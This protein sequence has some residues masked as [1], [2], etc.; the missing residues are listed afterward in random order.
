M[1][2]D[3]SPEELVQFFKALAEANR[4][5]MVGLLAQKPYTGEQLSVLLGLSVS[6]VS[7]HLSKLAK[8]GLVE[9]RAEGYYNVYS[10]KTN[11]LEEMARRVFSR[12]KLPR[13]AQNVDV[14]AFD[15]KVLQAFV[16]ADGR[17]MAFP[18]QEKKLLVI[19]RYVL[20][21]FEPGLRYPEKQVNEILS[22]FNEDTATLRRCLV[23]YHLMA[24][25]GGGGAYWRLEERT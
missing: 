12:E 8:A 24:R 6:T 10:L 18:K 11:V 20:K 14:D 17:I 19:L 15:H 4:L 13:L 25:E 9:A 5:K 3:G 21:A 16:D 23:D 1:M 2:E 22:R 7:H